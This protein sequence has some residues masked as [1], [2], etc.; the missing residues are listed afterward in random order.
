MPRPGAVNFFSFP[1]GLKQDHY[2]TD[3]LEARRLEYSIDQSR[4]HGFKK[5]SSHGADMPLSS[6]A[7]KKNIKGPLKHAQAEYSV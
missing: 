5:C 1:R 7:L 2:K 4:K 6:P 3:A